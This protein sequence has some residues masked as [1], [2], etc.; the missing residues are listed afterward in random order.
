ME[1][2]YIYIRQPGVVAKNETI[3]PLTG[4]E[5]AALRVVAVL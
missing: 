3:D 1:F 4:L 5:P 2:L